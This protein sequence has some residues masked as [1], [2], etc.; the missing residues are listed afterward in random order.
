MQR[1]YTAAG[2]HIPEIPW[3]DYPRPQLRR[4]EWLCLNGRWKLTAGEKTCDILVPFCPESLLSGAGEAPACGETM[5]YRRTF[6]VPD[7][8]AGQRIIL[9]FGA[10]NREAEVF[11]NG[12][13]VTRHENGYLPFKVDI[14]QNLKPEMN[15]L[16]VRVCNDLDPR[17][18]WGK[19]KVK[20]GGMWYTPVSGIWQTVWLEPVPE[21]HISG[22]S[23][24]NDLSSVRI[25]VCGV[26]EGSILFEGREISLHSGQAEITVPDPIHWTPETP[27]LYRFTIISG[28]DRVES[29]FALR[30]L[31]VGPDGNGIPRLCLNGKPFFFHGLLDQGYWSDGLYTPAGPELY[32]EDIR[33]AKEMGFNTL[34]KHIKI[35]PERFY[36]DCDRLGMVVFQDMVN[37]GPYDFL[38][39]TALPTLGFLRRD[40]RRLHPDPVQRAV[41]RSAMEATVEALGNHPSICLWTIFNEGWGQFRADEAYDRLKAL[42]PGRF[43]DTASGWFVPKK[44]DVESLHIYFRPLRLGKDRRRP[45][46]LSEYGGYARKLPEHSFDLEHTYGYRRYSDDASYVRALEE[47]FAKLFP[48]A[49]EGLC[50]AVYTQLSDV[51]DETNG[52]VT[53]DRREKKISPEKLRHAAERLKNAMK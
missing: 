8:W 15:E 46:F 41:F 38:R 9:H 28:E 5:T 50:A 37:S 13:S 43:V 1:L 36:Y 25:T 27:H 47:L 35:E 49:R 31:T 40:D 14:T 45:Q 30:T 33:A 12:V 44:S 48:L 22:I 4:E 24:E 18:P 51:E 3:N 52:L 39:D 21:R 7:T 53:F 26:S 42:D 29:Y 17:F 10:V 34:R 6:S 20:R 32:E 23:M 11:I 19:Q 16:S 2:E